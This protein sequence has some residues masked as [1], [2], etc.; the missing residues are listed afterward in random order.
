MNLFLCVYVF[1]LFYILSI[2]GIEFF[3]IP[4]MKRF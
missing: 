4:V 2:I 1:D 3:T